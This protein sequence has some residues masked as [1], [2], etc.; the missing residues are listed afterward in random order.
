MEIWGKYKYSLPP[1]PS[2]MSF[3]THPRFSVA[4]WC[5]D[6][7]YWGKVAINCLFFNDCMGVGWW[8]WI[9][10]KIGFF[11]LMEYGTIL[12]S[13]E[14]LFSNTFITE[15][16]FKLF[17]QWYLIPYQLAKIFPD[18]PNA[19]WW[20]GQ[21]ETTFSHICWKCPIIA[22]FWQQ[23]NHDIQS[24]VGYRIPITSKKCFIIWL[25]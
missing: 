16:R 20:C 22:I 25:S 5:S 3:M 13:Y 9:M 1:Y 14:Q 19:C 7:Y 6:F 4:A 23:I 17:Y 8:I 24:M 12:A 10:F 18:L 21:R 15:N 11:P 2:P